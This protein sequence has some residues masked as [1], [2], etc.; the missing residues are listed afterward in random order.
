MVTEIRATAGDEAE[1]VGACLPKVPAEFPIVHFR[2]ALRMVGAQ[3][4]EPDL[5]PEHERHLGRWAMEKFGS[6]FLIVEG[7]PAKK[8]PFYTHPQPDEPYWTNSFDL[9]FRGL[10]LVTGGQK[11]GVGPPWSGSSAAGE[12]ILHAGLMRRRVDLVWSDQTAALNRAVV[13]D[14]SPFGWSGCVGRS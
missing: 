4:D 12:S 7:Y 9:I 3:V 6:D 5:A 10:E 1:L 14:T 8:R 2:D 13:V 11:L